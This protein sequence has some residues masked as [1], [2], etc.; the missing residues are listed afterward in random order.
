MNYRIRKTLAD[1]K[2]TT[3]IHEDCQL[4][5]DAL[6][7]SLGINPF[8]CT[9]AIT[10]EI[11][12]RAFAA[13]EA[14]PPYPYTELKKAIANYLSPL[15]EIEPAQITLHNGSIGMI[16]HLNRMLVEEGTRI[17]AG[18]PSFSSAITDMR[19]MG[20]IIDLI[21]L[22]EADRFAFSSAAYLR[23]LEPEHALVY[24]DNPN[25]PTGQVIPVAELEKL[26]I[27]CLK[28]D[29]LLLVDEA[30]G[31]F[32][33]LQNS[34]LSLLEKYE[35]VIVLKTLSKGLG[36]AGLRTGY[37]VVPRAFV[38]YMQ[39]L[40]AE[41]AVTGIAAELAPYALADRTHLQSSIEKIRKNKEELLGF[42]RQLK[43][44]ETDNSVPITLL[45]TD[46]DVDLFAICLRNGIIGERGED[47]EGIGKRHIRLRVPREMK[48]LLPR[49]ALV[50]RELQKLP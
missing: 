44:A 45:Y 26:A 9:P 14:Y 38:P 21:Y 28:Q 46:K 13:I 5:A 48:T 24:I 11:F 39:K 25:N 33:A 43:A 30:Y 10:Q 17:L 36:L 22:K 50:E 32:M 42:C 2:L 18:G 35:N 37:A 47:F 34:S 4:P 7:C 40:P 20:G 31:D 1:Y 16:I 15:T 6:D 3:Y 12:A 29:T 49:L 27:A 19:A 41:M 8:G 23:A